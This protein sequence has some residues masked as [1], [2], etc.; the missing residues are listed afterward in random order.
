MHSMTF[1]DVSREEQVIV[2][3]FAYPFLLGSMC[4]CAFLAWQ[5]QKLKLLAQKI[6]NDKVRN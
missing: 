5:W 4:A 3:R 6:R 2:T 1:P